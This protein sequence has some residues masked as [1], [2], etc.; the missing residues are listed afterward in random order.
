MYPSTCKY[1]LVLIMIS[2]KIEHI[3]EWFFFFFFRDV[4][5]FQ[6]NCLISPHLGYMRHMPLMC[7]LQVPTMG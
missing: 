5:Y 6:S 2:K 3:G 7:D 1:E 4:F